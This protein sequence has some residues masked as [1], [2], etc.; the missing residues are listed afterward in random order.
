[1]KWPRWFARRRRARWWYEVQ[2]ASG[3]LDLITE[4]LTLPE[5]WARKVPYNLLDKEQ[6][7]ADLARAEAR[8]DLWDRRVP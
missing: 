2:R 3:D 7:Q 8:Y 6:A 5:P 4:C 1:M